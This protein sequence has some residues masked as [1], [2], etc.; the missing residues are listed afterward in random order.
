MRMTRNAIKRGGLLL[1]AALL[2]WRVLVN[3]LA[4]HYAGQE[5]PEGA[6]AALRWRGDQ[7]AALYQRGL[8][9]SE[10]EP[11]ASERWFQAAIWADPTDALAY[12]AL[13]ELWV[14]SGRQ[15]AAIGLVEIADVLAP[16]RSPALAR[17]AAFWLNQNRPDRALE[18]WSL[19]LR[20]RPQAAGQLYPV[21]LRLA[22]NPAAQPLLRPLLDKPPEWW[23]GFFAYAA[24]KA[25]RPETVMFLYQHR[26]RASG[27]PDIAE[28]RI[29][30]DR[31]WREGRWLEAYLAW[32]NGL[33][34]RQQ[35]GLGHLYNGGFELP[36]TG[37]GFDWRMSP[38]RGA[39]VETVETY[40]TRGGR[41]LHVTFD[42]QR[43]HFQHV[44]QP[45]YLEPGRYQLQGRV[46]PDRLQAERGLRWRVRCG[47]QSVRVLA[48]SEPFVGSD[49][50][51]SFT[52]DFTVPETDCAVQLLRLELEG[53]AELDF[54]AQGGIWFDD[55]TIN[56]R[57]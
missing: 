8:A 35:Q 4:E 27:P 15:L 16:M 28:Q 2:A 20:T 26:S 3:G 21:L 9:S 14:G 57:G 30:L 32:L 56:R 10:R 53:R 12:L 49:D 50:W 11:V 43:V 54:T 18:R 40:G 1:V 22:D 38:P 23:D 17:S 44:Y 33:D 13:A 42:G 36:V 45:L 52:A 7:P 37:M 48:E 34:E 6:S 19:L 51:R 31:L 47:G 5:T 24:A 29:Y 39:T 41:A 46:R 55:L 25:E